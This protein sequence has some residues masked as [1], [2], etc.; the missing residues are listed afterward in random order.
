M[1]LVKDEKFEN[2]GKSRE[3]S[4][5]IGKNRHICYAILLLHCN[6]DSDMYQYLPIFTNNVKSAAS[7]EV[8]IGKYWQNR[9]I[10]VNIRK[11]W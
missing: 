10:S 6:S 11:Y 5:N 3:M 9:K 1:F 4:G 8:E 7:V 2:I